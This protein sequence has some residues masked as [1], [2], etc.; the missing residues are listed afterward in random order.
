MKRK[1]TV[2]IEIEAINKDTCDVMCPY[3]RTIDKE[4]YCILFSTRLYRGKRLLKRTE[5]CKTAEASHD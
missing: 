2:E 3:C 4:Y 5:K 1:V